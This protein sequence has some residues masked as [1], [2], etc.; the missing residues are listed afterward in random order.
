MTFFC[1]NRK[2]YPKIHMNT[3]PPAVLVFMVARQL[4]SAMCTMLLWPLL[5]TQYYK[6]SVLSFVT[7]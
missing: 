7:L 3:V 5:L 1:G 4:T 6:F 2:T